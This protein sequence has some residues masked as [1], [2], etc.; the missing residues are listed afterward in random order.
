M[1]AI[2][3]AGAA[4]VGLPILLHLIMKQEPKRLTF[5]AFRFLTQKLKTN[6]RKLRLRHFVLLAMRML[7]IA[8]FCL[9]LYQPT[10][11]S[12]RF[13]IV[14]D[15]PVAVVIVIDTS[16]SMGYTANQK[17]RLDEARRRAL[18]LLDT[19]PDKSPV[20]IV[21]TDELSARW[22][23]I[24]EARKQLE[25][26]DK[27]RGGNQPVTSAI[28]VAYQLLAKIEGAEAEDADRLPKLVAVFTDRTAASWDT[29]RVEDLKKL[30]ETLP[31][32][33]PTHMRLRRRGRTPDERRHP[34]GRDEAA[35]HLREPEGH[36]HGHGG[37]DRPRDR[38]GGGSDCARE[39]RRRKRR[40]EARQRALRPVASGHVRVREAQTGRASGRVQPRG[41]RQAHVRQHAVPDLQGRRGPAHPHHRR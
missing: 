21:E 6:Q 25:K 27:P 5:P 34:R 20:A 29:S 8:L 19:L 12:E 9:T 17:S 39:D 30:R 18:E 35:G 28:A 3:I 33:K 41:E 10:L 14:G 16:P 15:Q 1:H 36:R 2:L 7:L 24:A 22:M 11:L 31:D 37:R 32:P 40:A 26:I 23:D 4:L 38:A 13:G